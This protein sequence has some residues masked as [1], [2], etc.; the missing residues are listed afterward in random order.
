M[1]AALIKIR[2]TVVDGVCDIETS[3]QTTSSGICMQILTSPGAP[4]MW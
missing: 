4:Y 2:S 1:S 3:T